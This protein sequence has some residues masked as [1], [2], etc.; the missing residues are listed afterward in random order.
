MSSAPRDIILSAELKRLKSSTR[1][2]VRDLGGTSLV[3]EELGI[4][5]QRVSDCQ[6]VNTA[7]FLRIDEVHA[8]EEATRG[9]PGWPAITRAQARNHGF[10]LMPLPAAL[11][12]SPSWHQSIADVSREAADVVAVVAQA[13]ANDGDVSAREICDANIVEEIDE[14]IGKLMVLRGRCSAALEGDR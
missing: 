12:A 7:D 13:L 4:R 10:E 14:A 8:L 9:A 5:Q 2:A 6:L 3:A 11:D 1:R